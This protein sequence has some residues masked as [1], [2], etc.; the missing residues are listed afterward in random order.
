MEKKLFMIGNAHLDPVWLWQWPDGFHEAKAT[1]RSALDRM[2][3]YPN[4]VFVSSAAVTYEWI[5]QN[6]PQMFA[7]IRQAIADGRW[8]VVGGWWIEPDCNIP[9]GESFARQGLYGQR[10]FFEKFGVTAKA[11][12]NVDSFGH[13]GMLP[14]ILKKSGLDYYVFMRPSPHEKGL[15]GRLFWWEADDGTRVLTFQVPYAYCT[16][17]EDLTQNVL[18]VASELNDPY[19]QS[20]CFYGVGNHGGGP[21]RQNLDSILEMKGV[22]GVPSLVM[23]SPEEFFAEAL[24]QAKQ[25]NTVFPVVHDDLQ[26]HASGCYSSHSGIKRWNR[27]A[28]NRLLA[29]EKFSSIA[30]WQLGLPYSNEFD[31][32]WKNVLFNQFHDILAGTCIEPAYDDARDQFGEAISIAE[33][34]LNNSVQALA[35]NVAIEP[36]PGLKPLVI[37]N[38]NAWSTVT[39]IEVECTELMPGEVLLDDTGQMVPF[40]KIQSAATAPERTRLTFNADLPALGYRVYRIVPRP[41]TPDFATVQ[42]SDTAGDTVMENAHLRIEFDPET[43]YIRSLKDKHKQIEVFMTPGAVPVVIDDPSDTWSHNVFRYDRVVGAFKARS[44]R[45]VENGPVKAVIRVKSEYAE[46]GQPARSFLTQDFTLY[47]EQDRID[48]SVKV[49][50]HEKFKMLKLRF[51]LNLHSMRSTY[52]IPYGHIVREAYGEEEPAQN[53]VDV[54]GLSRDNNEM[55]GLSLLN[56]GKYSFDVN[57]RDIGMTVLRSPVYANH[58]P[59]VPEP[60]GDYSFI[61]QGEQRFHYALLPHSDGWKEAG[62]VRQAAELNQRPIVLQG[63]SHTGTLPQA[64]SFMQVT[65]D[66][67]IVTVFKKAEDSEDLI[68]RCYETAGTN[69]NGIID[70]PDFNR[71]IEAHFGP[72]EIK[73]FRIPKDHS[74]PVIETNILEM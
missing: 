42:A 3:E 2:K 63:T 20:M 1:F 32:A 15:P 70:V 22:P 73:T 72:C 71:R 55:Y 19:N 54:S 64:K 27:Q 68:L 16:W 41:Q 46:A 56:D 33:R 37:F 31:R 39:N 53:W 26:H 9:C 74:L 34:A 52:E 67:L 18:R 4:F 25:N 28:E 12:Y 8:K 58:M 57:I 21:T 36:E 47:A 40:Q 24:E 44:V 14:Q 38:P 5:E 7:E 59:I 69:T 51:P 6:D 11:G 61:D 48:V 17:G 66:D 43:G 23:S 30:A 62:T 65:P 29:A 49:D 60:D 50:W 10:Y 35:W 45:L 13:N